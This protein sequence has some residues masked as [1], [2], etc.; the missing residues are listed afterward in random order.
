M[1]K[2]IIIGELNDETSDDEIDSIYDLLPQVG[3]KNIKI[4]TQVYKEGDEVGIRK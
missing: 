3:I 1:T 4:E 2:I